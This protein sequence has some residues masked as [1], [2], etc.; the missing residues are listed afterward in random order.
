M[1]TCKSQA[2]CCACSLIQSHDCHQLL[3]AFFLGGKGQHNFLCYKTPP[4]LFWSSITTRKSERN[5]Q[6]N[7]RERREKI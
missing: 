6:K 7:Q 5:F 4:S 2:A 3:A 1:G